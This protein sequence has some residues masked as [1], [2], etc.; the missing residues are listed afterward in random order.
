MGSNLTRAIEYHY[1]VTIHPKISFKQ[2]RFHDNLPLGHPTQRSRG[3]KPIRELMLWQAALLANHDFAHTWYLHS[4]SQPY[5][6]LRRGVHGG[7]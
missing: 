4:G 5:T 6:T 7:I 3:G 2:T 1:F